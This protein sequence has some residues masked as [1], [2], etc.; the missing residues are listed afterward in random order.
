MNTMFSLW[1]SSVSAWGLV[2]WLVFIV[3]AGACIGI[4]YVALRVFGVAIPDWAVKIFWIVVAACVA[5][6]AI[7]F[8]A[9]L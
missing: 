7:R 6:L 1:Q 3:I 4:V 2:D 8:V 9:S 5:V